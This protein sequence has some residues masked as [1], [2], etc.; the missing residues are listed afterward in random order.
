MIYLS[1]PDTINNIGAGQMA[2]MV[3]KGANVFPS[4]SEKLK[5][6]VPTYHVHCLTKKI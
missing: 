2:L 3:I 6:C 1:L 5:V 4:S